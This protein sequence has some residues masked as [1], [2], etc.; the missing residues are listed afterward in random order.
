MRILSPWYR[1]LGM[2]QCSWNQRMLI[3]V[4]ETMDSEFWELG[5]VKRMSTGLE[6]CFLSCFTGEEPT[7]VCSTSYSIYNFNG[8]SLVEWI[9]HLLE[10]SSSS[11]Q[12]A[13]D[14]ALIGQRF[15]DEIF[16]FLKD[17][18][19]IQPFSDRRQKMLQVYK[20]LSPIIGE[21][22]GIVDDTR[23]NC[24]GK[25]IYIISKLDF[26]LIKDIQTIIFST[27]CSTPGYNDT[28][29]IFILLIMGEKINDSCL[30]LWFYLLMLCSIL[31]FS[32]FF[33][34]LYLLIIVFYVQG[35]KRVF[36]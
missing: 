31:L 17:A 25:P 36:N 21:R 13:I 18:D 11:L 32:M 4:G 23:W 30:N 14:K 33:S 35:K 3:Q 19:C 26:E 34:L 5:Y 24:L 28:I 1:V 22:Y 6:L 10:C 29:Y 16:Q 9:T 20:T 15:D 12:I 8:N 2:Q 7:K 27:F